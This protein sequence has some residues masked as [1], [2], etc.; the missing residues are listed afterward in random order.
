MRFGNPRGSCGREQALSDPLR[1]VHRDSIS[2]GRVAIGVGLFSGRCR[3]VVRKPLKAL[4]LDRHE[5]AHAG[6]LTHRGIPLPGLPALRLQLRKDVRF[7]GSSPRWF[8]AKETEIRFCVSSPEGPPDPLDHFE[9]TA[10]DTSWST[11]SASIR[12][13]PS[14]PPARG[15]TTSGCLSV[16]DPPAP[17]ALRVPSGA[18]SMK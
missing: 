18:P 4:R 12:K 15:E 14:V 3:P 10:S 9:V 16:R 13:P 1:H 7:A 17:F 5:S 8:S 11:V 6:V 2:D